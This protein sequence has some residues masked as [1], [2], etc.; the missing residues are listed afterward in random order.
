MVQNI[1]TCH[2]VQRHDAGVDGDEAD[3]LYLSDLPDVSDDG[4]LR[5]SYSYQ[6]ADS[7]GPPHTLSKSHRRRKDRREKMRREQGRRPYKNVSKAV[8]DEA[9]PPIEVDWGDAQE[10]VTQGSYFS[11]ATEGKPGCHLISKEVAL[12][13]GLVEIK[14]D[15]V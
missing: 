9:A 15:G 4:D 14:W 6:Q 5:D 8:I 12:R 7:V 13:M 1:L 11:R 10:R 2:I 3:F